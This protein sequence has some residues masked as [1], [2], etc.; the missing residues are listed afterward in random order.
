[1]ERQE[2]INQVKIKAAEISPFEDNEAIESPVIDALLDAGVK[3]ILLMAP[4]HLLTATDF[5]TDS[6]PNTTDNGD[7]TGSIVLPD[8]FLRLVSFKMS[9]WLRPVNRAIS[10][11]DSKYKL[12]FNAYTR[13]GIAKPVVAIRNDGSQKILEYFS[14]VNNNHDVD[15]ALC[16]NAVTAQ[17]LQEDM[18]EPLTWLMVSKVFYVDEKYDAANEAMKRVNEYF[19]NKII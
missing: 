2:I 18:V 11:S 19:A 9:C 8:D 5:Y 16:I 4:I 14:V 15:T 12:Q 10:E 6:N 3:E 17:N 7:N 13:G 1:M